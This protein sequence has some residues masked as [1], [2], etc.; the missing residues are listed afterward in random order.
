M[1][2]SDPSDPNS[3]NDSSQVT[4]SPTG[5]TPPGG[6][7]LLLDKTVNGVDLLEA[8]VGDTITYTIR[9]LHDSDSVGDATN[10]TISDTDLPTNLTITGVTS[11]LDGAPG[12]AT[13]NPFSNTLS[14]TGLNLANGSEARI[15]VTATINSGGGGLSYNNTACITAMTEADTEMNNNCDDA[16]FQIPATSSGMDLLLEKTVN[17]VDLLTSEVGDVITYTIRVAHDSDSVGDATGITITDAD[18]PTNLTGITVV[19]ALVDGAVAGTATYTAGTNTLSWS[20]FGL[21]NSSVGI[22]TLTAMI[23]DGVAGQSYRNEACITAVAETDTEANNN[24]DEATFQLTGV[25]LLLEKTVNGV[26]LHTA[27]IGDVITYTIRVAHDTDSVGDATNVTITDNSLPSNLTGI[28][29]VSSLVDG[30]ISGTA[31]YT[32]GI[33]TLTW[34]GFNIANNS[35]GLLTVTATI[36]ASTPGLA[37]RNEACITAMTET[38]TEM[39]NNCD[40]AIFQVAGSGVSIDKE[41]QTTTVTA[42]N[43]FLTTYTIQV[44]NGPQS[45]TNAMVIDPVG[46][47]SGWDPATSTAI[48]LSATLESEDTAGTWRIPTPLPMD[49]SLIAELMSTS[50]PA[51]DNA[52]FR[53]VV[54]YT[55]DDADDLPITNIATVS[56]VDPQNVT[57]MSS[58]SSDV[59]PTNDDLLNTQILVTKEGSNPVPAANGAVGWYDVNFVVDFTN[60][61]GD[62]ISN[63]VMIDNLDTTLCAAANPWTNCQLVG[64]PQVTPTSFMMQTAATINADFTTNWLVPGQSI[65][66]G[67]NARIEYTVRF[68]A[69]GHVGP[70]TN[71]VTVSGTD[72]NGDPVSDDGIEIVQL[73]AVM[74]NLIVDKELVDVEIV[75]F[76]SFRGTFEVRVT[77]T[78]EVDL[79]NVIVTDDLSL[80]GW[81][82]ASNLD[83][84]NSVDNPGDADLPVITQSV[85]PNPVSTL[86]FNNNYATAADYVLASGPMEADSTATIRFTVEFDVTDADQLPIDNLASAVGTDMF[87]QTAYDQ[88]NTLVEEADIAGDTTL[89]IEKDAGMVIRVPGQA[90]RY[91]TIFTIDVV[92]TSNQPIYN[93]L[94]EDPLTGSLMQTGGWS[95]FNITSIDV[96]AGPISIVENGTLVGTSPAAG[97]NYLQDTDG[98]GPLPTLQGGEQ[99]TL[100]FEAEFDANGVPGP[101][102]NVATA[103]GVN[104]LNRT[105]TNTTVAPVIVDS[106]SDILVDKEV[107]ETRSTG[108]GTY[109]TTFEVQVANNG[110]NILSNVQVLDSMTFA[111]W[112]GTGSHSL[113]TTAPYGPIVVNSTDLG[114]TSY[115]SF[116]NS[117]LTAAD[118]NLLDPAGLVS[119][120]SGSMDPGSDAV[121]R[122][123]INYAVTDSSQIP[124]EN[125]AIATGIGP[126]GQMAGASDETQF[127]PIIGNASVD[128]DKEAIRTI[129]TG[130]N[131]FETVFTIQVE[132]GLQDLTNVQVLDDLVTGWTAAQTTAQITS[133]RNI[134]NNATQ[135]TAWTLGTTPVANGTNAL[136]ASTP[137]FVANEEFTFEV[138]VAYTVLAGDIANLPIENTATI[139]GT[140]PDNNTQI[141]TDTTLVYDVTLATPAIDLQLAKSVSNNNP[142]MGDRI[143][144][145][146]VVANTGVVDATNV[147]VEDFFPTGLSF[148]SATPAANYNSGTNI[149][150]VGTLAASGGNAT[151]TLVA[152]VTASSGTITNCAEVNSVDQTTDPDSTPNNF[153]TAF[154]AQEDDEACV[155][156]TVAT[157]GI[158]LEL[159]KTVSSSVVMSGDRITYTVVV[160]NT[161]DTAATNVV[162]EDFFPAGLSFVSATPA[163]NYNSGTGLWTVG[164]VAAMGGTSTLTIV[165]DVTGAAGSTITNCAEVNSVDQT[166]DP[167]STPNN[168]NTTA[169]EDDEACVTIMVATPGIDLM[170]SKT[171]SATTAMTGDRITYTVVVMNTGDTAA[172]NVTVEDFFPAGLNLVSATPAANYNTGTNIWTVGTVAA[173]G[174]T[175]TLTL[176]A[177]VT[178]ASGTITNC[179]EV[180]SVDQTTDPDSTPNN[181]NTTAQEDDEACVSITVTTPAID[182]ELAKTVSSAS[183]MTGDRITYTV[184][185]GNTG[186]ATATNVV[187][188]DFFPAGLSF[189]SATPAANYNSGTGLWTVG[190]VAGSGGTSVLTIVADVTATSGTITNCAEVNSVDQTTDPDS[191][192]NNFN[193]TAQEDDE[194]CVTITVTDTP[195]DLELTKTVSAASV[196]TSDRITYT[197]TVRNTGGATATNVTVEDFFPA[198]LNFVSA[199]PAANY[200]SGTNIWTVGTVASSGGTS[201]LTIVADVTATSGTIT[202]CAEVNSVDQTNDPDSTPNNFN[203]TAQ[204]DDEACVTIAVPTDM[205]LV[206]KTVNRPTV[207]I[208]DIVVFTLRGT[209]QAGTAM[210]IDVIDYMPPGFS[211]VTG[212]G[213][214]DGV[215]T[216]P[217]L[218]GADLI[219]EDVF[220][221]A[222][223]ASGSTATDDSYEVTFVARA[224]AGAGLGKHINRHQA[225]QLNT[226][227]PASELV[228]AMVRIVEEPCL[229]LF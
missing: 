100:Q 52:T 212:S 129:S 217:T 138:V 161:G 199:T 42:M 41:T 91:R 1:T 143:T 170:L 75:G 10:V 221:G 14:W 17:G 32:A 70:E 211:Y 72:T 155:D 163:A 87:G 89:S 16:A 178:A 152:D 85:T 55:V 112:T 204:E 132:N 92:N 23:N 119:P 64:D 224:N 134:T 111:G 133:I 151:L 74:P 33:N 171:V 148:V 67:G 200:N 71:I 194:A 140:D 183:V 190:T 180:N 166:T 6:V 48:I 66:D 209:N 131:S 175:S 122:F 69:N 192:P 114:R 15:L 115:L 62:T 43:Q 22:L 218:S 79:D 97:V 213:K 2:V 130:T 60:L 37:Y 202:N 76:Q 57:Q 147:T 182:L 210:T 9:V 121:I 206:T 186:A 18:L 98:T 105:L 181:F 45:L 30:F 179:A 201:V 127:N 27:Q 21:S 124:L 35:V 44:T 11:T 83:V 168:F 77:N 227:V 137:L 177:D 103:T 82:A 150:T 225:L 53:V 120:R 160:S 110:E 123:T 93:L 191:T 153:L 40:D 26:D 104:A 107:I 145:T 196:M 51:G 81:S 117:Y 4:V 7:D 116:N 141:A 193:T 187:V 36:G 34:S 58:N 184:T 189:V 128:I 159:A 174:G 185:V 63:L 13:Y 195:I 173:M 172:T 214:L 149:W 125:E 95:N 146:I 38:D 169:Q 158:D 165:A 59:F 39:N 88:D 142:A 25:D 101:L 96:V 118:Y 90:D 46:A 205:I 19:S 208:G 28:T 3:A 223:G 99:V 94:L 65:A 68:N 197:L 20:G 50:W 154:G 78:G 106:H 216:E 113:E 188:E 157:P 86:V 29:V 136:V 198:G 47:G 222:N 102:N 80:A 108:P 219:W 144:Y 135:T 73:S 56:G 49:G 84:V 31:T 126:G 220:L 207:S 156:I 203:T 54:S 24:C 167:D 61:S 8:A 139:T 176:V 162:V 12:A 228:M 109:A 164:T 215:A 226:N 229:R 5:C